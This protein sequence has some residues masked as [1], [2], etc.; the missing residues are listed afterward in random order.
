MIRGR[1]LGGVLA[2]GTGSYAPGF[3]VLAVCAAL[4]SV[5][6]LLARRPEPPRRYVLAQ[7]IADASDA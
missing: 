5:F 4:G 2:D 3:G 1:I 7:P 6:F